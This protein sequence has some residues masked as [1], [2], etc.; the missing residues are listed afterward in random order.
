MKENRFL[1]FPALS[2]ETLSDKYSIP[3]ED[4]S[5]LP[6]VKEI[7]NSDLMHANCTS[8]EVNDED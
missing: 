4:M 3:P 8:E 1:N 6:T 2:E 5:D 7:V